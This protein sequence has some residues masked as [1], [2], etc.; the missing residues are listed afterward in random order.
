MLSLFVIIFH[1]RLAL[2]IPSDSLSLCGNC[3]FF[4]IF[5]NSGPVASTV[6]A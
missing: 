1:E 3:A 2:V 5:V 6:I 4:R